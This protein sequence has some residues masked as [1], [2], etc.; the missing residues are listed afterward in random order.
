MFNF[1]ERKRN[2]IID[3]IYKK[4]ELEKEKENAIKLESI[5]DLAKKIIK[6]EGRNLLP[7]KVYI[8]SIGESVRQRYILK[9]YCGEKVIMA[10]DLFEDL[11]F[12]LKKYFS[13]DT[14]REGDEYEY[15]ICLNKHLII[16][17]AWNK[18]RF[19]SNVTKIGRD[20]NNPFSYDFINHMSYLFFPIGIVILYN[21][22]H[23]V[24]TGILKNEGKIKTNN[25]FDLRNKYNQIRF[26]GTYY[27]EI[28]TD[29]ILH[30]VKNFE[31]GAI[32]EIGR[33]L[34]ENNIDL[35]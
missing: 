15:E 28:E 10:A 31:L 25:A 33:V 11:G 27:R 5:I 35:F 16:P 20:C 14:S 21:G 13:E 7:I 26:D 22:N 32:F 24:L 17:A 3:D 2:K 30:K 19:V 12:R 1:L 6:E 34:A 29:E 9:L 23:S 18:D 4:E 8:D